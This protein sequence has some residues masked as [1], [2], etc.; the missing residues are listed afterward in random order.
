MLGAKSSTHEVTES[1]ASCHIARGFLRVVFI[2]DAMLVPRS[3][4]SR[5]E[6]RKLHAIGAATP[7][8]TAGI[9][10]AA[11]RRPDVQW[12]GAHF[13]PGGPAKKH[14]PRGATCRCRT[15]RRSRPGDRPR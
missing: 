5:G 2:S 14:L 11:L 10:R 6:F 13:L 15:A 4:R 3:S 12:P 9:G 1:R 7:G 8:T